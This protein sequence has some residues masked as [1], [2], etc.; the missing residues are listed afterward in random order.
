MNRHYTFESYLEKVN[1]IRSFLPNCSISTDIMVGFPNESEEDFL[2]TMKMVETVKFDGA[3]TFV[4]SRRKGTKAD[5]MDN[6]IDEETKKQRIIKLVDKVNE[7]NRQ[8]SLTYVN[9]VV[10]VLCEDYDSKKD[11]YLGRDES[12]RMIYFKSENSLIGKFVNVK[13]TETGGISLYG[14]LE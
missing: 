13:I 6:Q 14:E 2:D 10:E 8:K 9:R 7:I 3:F 1:M 12:N 11:L 4:Y 5:L